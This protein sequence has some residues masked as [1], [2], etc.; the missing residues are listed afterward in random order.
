M[1]IKGEWIRYGNKKGYFAYPEHAN[2]PL[3]AIIVI[4]EAWGVNG[5]IEDLTR[6]FA[7]A[8]Y[9]AIAPDLFSIDGERP[10]ALTPER[11]DAAVN[12]F[13]SI[14]LQARGNPSMRETELMKLPKEDADSIQETLAKI[15]SGAAGMQEH[16][17]TLRETVSFL[18]SEKPETRRQKVACVGFCMG[19]G[20]SALLACEEPELSGAAIFYGT[21]PPAEKIS[22]IK[23]PVIGFYGENDPRINEGIPVFSSEIA[24]TGKPF[25]HYIYDD[26]L[27]SFFNDDNPSYNV[28]AVRDS[29]MRLIAFFHKTLSV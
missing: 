13:R 14:P 17:S 19:G 23:C 26:A 20:L 24:K 10:A 11:I 15:F 27:H 28:K 22:S 9:A 2:I 1:A 12:F 7:S 16:L 25:D 8:G 4:Q 21:T 6:R 29:F 18:Q 5:H 3:P